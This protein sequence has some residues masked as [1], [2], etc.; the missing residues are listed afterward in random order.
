MARDIKFSL[1]RNSCV[2]N[3]DVQE[4]SA[5]YP[6]GGLSISGLIKENKKVNRDKR[7]QILLNFN[8]IANLAKIFNAQKEEKVEIYHS[9]TGSR[10]DTTGKSLVVH[11]RSPDAVSITLNYMDKQNPNNSLSIPTTAFDRGVLWCIEQIAKEALLCSAD[12]QFAS[13][14]QESNSDNEVPF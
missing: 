14:K 10:E 9:P 4:P 2:Y 5:K 12:K 1:Y 6:T 7:V 13:W 8:D 3:F 11:R